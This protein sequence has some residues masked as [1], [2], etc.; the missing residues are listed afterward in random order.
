MVYQSRFVN[1]RGLLWVYDRVKKSF[2][3]RH[4][5]VICCENDLYAVKP[6]GAPKDQ[7]LES[8]AL[9]QA[10]GDCATG[11]RTLIAPLSGLPGHYVS[12][13]ISTFVGL[14]YSRLPFMREFITTIWE[15]GVKE[16]MRLTAVT[17][18]RMQSVI[19]SYEHDTGNK[20]EVSAKTMVEAI[21]RDGLNV[22]VSEIPFLKNVIRTAKVVADTVIRA[23][24]QVLR[25]PAETGFVL[26]DAP[27]VV[28]PPQGVR[29]VGFHVPGT[30]TYV[31]LSRGACL[32]LSNRRRS[33]LQYRDVDS[34]TVGLIN[35]NIAASSERFIMGPAKLEL[36]TLVP[37]SGCVTIYPTPRV[38]FQR[39]AQNDDGSIEVITFNPRNYFYLPDGRTP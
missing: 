20:I 8:V 35:Q 26:C 7:R 34:H 30:V 29:Q 33:R 12:S 5:K 25:A 24:W 3:E 23:S 2:G 19:N 37:L 21:Q 31:P 17:E 13:L 11:I 15:R 4:P 1:E 36:E 39:H 38:T 16:T 22:V 6:E 28:V 9:A 14:Q 10:D 18:G 27:V 32:R